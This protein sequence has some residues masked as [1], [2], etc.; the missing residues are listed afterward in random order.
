MREEN[1][2]F[3]G[4]SGAF[5]RNSNE[6]NEQQHEKVLTASTTENIKASTIIEKRSG[7]WKYVNLLLGMHLHLKKIIP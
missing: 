2:N 1:A 3:N 7:G 5:Q 4:E 6:N